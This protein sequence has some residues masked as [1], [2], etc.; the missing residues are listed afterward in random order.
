MPHNGGMEDRSGKKD[1]TETA[2]DE[3]LD[4]LAWVIMK[5]YLSEHP[6]PTAM[7]TLSSAHPSSGAS[8]PDFKSQ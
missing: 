5:M 3:A 2:I 1:C 8:R 6:L 7:G 4:Q